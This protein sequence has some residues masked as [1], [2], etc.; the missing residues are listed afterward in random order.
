MTIG[1]G[2]KTANV[3]AYLLLV[4]EGTSFEIETAT[5]LRQPEVSTGLKEIGS[6][7]TLTKIPNTH[8]SKYAL[9]SPKEAINSIYGK[10]LETRKIQD[11]AYSRIIQMV[12]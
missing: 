12:E 6:W 3:L 2:R 10:L 9:T 7:L 5:G 1:F 4:G 11:A 8:T